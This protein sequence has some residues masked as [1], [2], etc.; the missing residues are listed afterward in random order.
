M[1]NNKLHMSV[2]ILFKAFKM[3]SQEVFGHRNL[4]QVMNDQIHGAVL[5]KKK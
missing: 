1:E 5:A 4:N 2:S 3:E